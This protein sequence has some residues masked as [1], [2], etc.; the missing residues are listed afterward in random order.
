[1]VIFVALSIFDIQRQDL[2]A[3]VLALARP[4]GLRNPSN[5]ILTHLLMYCNEDLMNSIE[6]PSSY[7]TLHFIHQTGRYD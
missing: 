4:L 6:M 5:E 3:G 2:L 1:M 7:L